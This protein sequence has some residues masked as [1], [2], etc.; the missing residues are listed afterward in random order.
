MT[1]SS[2]LRPMT[3]KHHRTSQLKTNMY[4]YIY[5]VTCIIHDLCVYI[6]REI[7]FSLFIFLFVR[8]CLY[9]K[10][11]V[12]AVVHKMWWNET[13]YTRKYTPYFVMIFSL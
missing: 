9:F 10:R 11:S 8:I 7:N 1:D 4:L 3:T 2:V 5:Y 12:D 13:L 6:A